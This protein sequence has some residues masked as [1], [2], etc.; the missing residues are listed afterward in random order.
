MLGA[1]AHILDRALAGGDFVITQQHRIGHTNLVGIG[2][3]LLELLVFTVQL[4][5]QA[6]AAQA[7]CQ[8]NSGGGVLR[9]GQNQCVAGGGGQFGVQK[10]L[11]VQH[12]EQT[13]QADGNAHTGQRLID[14]VAGQIVVAAAGADGADFG[15][16]Q[17]GGFIHGAGVVVQTA[18]DG[19]I[20]G[21]IGFRHTKGRQVGT[22]SLQLGKTQ[23]EQLVFAA[24]AFQSGNHIAIAAGD[25]D[26]LQNLIGFFL[27]DF[28]LADQQRTNLLSANL[29][30][31]VHSAHDVAAL[32]G[33]VHH[34]IETVEDLAV[35]HPNLESLQAEATEDLVND[36][37]DF[38][39]VENVQL[40]IA[41]DV[42]VGLIEFTEAATLG[43]LATVDLGDLVAAEGEGQFIVVQGHIFCQR[44][45]QVKA[46]GQVGITFLEAV[47]LLFGLAAALGQQ[48]LG[49]LDGGGV[50][51]GK[52][53][54]SIGFAENF[55]HP[56]QLR[57]LAG[58]QFHKTG[59][60]PGLDNAHNILRFLFLN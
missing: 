26:E 18:G 14:V 52:A 33:K 38:G 39:L 58:Q 17:Q 51:S 49:I 22:N 60:S 28:T 25:G 13:G 16:V 1:T 3:L 36:G 42:D 5:P 7:F 56:L 43:A 37:G 4:H 53:V 34:G 54:G 40:A 29:V 27:A 11:L 41:N 35:V 32:F 59:Q 45:R 44:H 24:V 10:T 2:H 55:H 23:V 9:H 57:L 30:Q 47:D 19:Q 6:I 8:S 21:K 20:H 48:N 50:Q 12:V 15:M 31:L 46:Q